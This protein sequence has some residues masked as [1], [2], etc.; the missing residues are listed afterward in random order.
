MK[1]DGN[2]VTLSIQRLPRGFLAMAFINDK[3]FQKKYKTLH[4][5]IHDIKHIARIM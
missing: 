2:I 3:F 5:A 1:R 4:E